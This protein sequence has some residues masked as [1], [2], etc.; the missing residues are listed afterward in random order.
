MGADGWVGL[1]GGGFDDRISNRVGATLIPTWRLF[2]QRGQTFFT[3]RRRHFFT[4]DFSKINESSLR[5]RIM[6]CQIDLVDNSSLSDNTLS[7][8]MPSLCG[9]Y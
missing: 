8:N 2:I 4:L 7:S 1:G 3:E 9:S 6:L 5:R